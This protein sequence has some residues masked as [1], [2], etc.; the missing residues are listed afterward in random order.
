V[1]R[2]ST[3][4]PAEQDRRV[5]VANPTQRLLWQLDRS[6]SPR[7]VLTAL[8]FA[9]VDAGALKQAVT[10]VLGRHPALRSRFQPAADGTGLSYRTDGDPPPVKLAARRRRDM[11]GPVRRTAA[12]RFDL[13]RDAP[14]RATVVAAGGGRAVLALCAHR[15]VLDEWSR[16][17]LVTQIGEAYRA[18]GQHRIPRL[19]DPSHPADVE[20]EVDSSG[21]L[22]AALAGQRGAP[23]EVRLP[24]DRPW[25]NGRTG[26]RGTHA[27]SLGPELTER[28]RGVAERTGGTSLVT[29]AA[30][31]AATLAAETAQQDFLFGFEWLGRRQPERRHVVGMFTNTLLLRVDLTGEPGWPALLA[32][33]RSA[34]RTSVEHADTP[35]AAVAEALGMPAVPPVMVNVHGGPF[36]LPRLGPGASCREM[37]MPSTIVN[38]LT[39]DVTESRD[40]M[41]ITIGYPVEAF[42]PATVHRMLVRLRRHAAELVNSL[43]GPLSARSAGDGLLAGLA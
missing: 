38:G 4:T 36:Q 15:I 19:A 3:E 25:P 13:T 9:G 24:G 22:A 2:G 23:V 6:D 17:L 35:F 28:L 29:I 11:A 31:L 34:W 1:E 12:E 8:E 39:L 43:G 20:V 16:Q 5:S 37:P 32:R 42:D 7:I 14:A 27:A 10:L 18:L 21:R 26:E 33:V 40:D 41:A 30:L